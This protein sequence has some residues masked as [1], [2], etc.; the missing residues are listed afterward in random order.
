MCYTIPNAVKELF[1]SILAAGLF[2]RQ[3]IHGQFLTLQKGMFVLE[4]GRRTGGNVIKPVRIDVRPAYRV[5][6]DDAMA[7]AW[8]TFM[9]FEAKDYTLE[10]IESFQDFITDTVLYRMFLMGAYQLFG[11]Y[12][13][14]IMVGMISLRNETH[15]SLLFVD[16]KYHKKGIGRMLIDYVSEYVW[17]EE[18]HS[19]ITVNAAP[20]AVGFYHRVGFADTGTEQTREG[21]RYTPM[22]R[23]IKA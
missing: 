17:A 19:R 6:W 16:R 12:D 5:E 22:E 20:Y 13:N 3:Y 8:R 14:G 1:R 21:V 2:D 23:N 9:Q 4:F 15:I 18:G 7:L 11:A 10:G